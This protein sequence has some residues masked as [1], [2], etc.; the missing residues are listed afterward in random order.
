MHVN[1]T[2][3]MKVVLHFRC[4]TFEGTYLRILIIRCHFRIR[5]QSKTSTDDFKY[6]IDR[7]LSPGCPHTPA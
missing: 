6:L 2:T 4:H 3:E 5:K 1:M 7:L